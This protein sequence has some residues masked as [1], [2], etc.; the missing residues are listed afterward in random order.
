MCVTRDRERDSL[1]NTKYLVLF[2]CTTILM[3]KMIS[4]YRSNLFSY[5]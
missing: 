3:K 1:V 2:I 4:F 5:I